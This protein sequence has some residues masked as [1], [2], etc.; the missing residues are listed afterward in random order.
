MEGIQTKVTLVVPV[1][2]AEAGAARFLA[3]HD[4]AVLGI[5]RGRLG[6]LTDIRPEMVR[7]DVAAVLDGRFAIEERFLL[8]VVVER[9][10]QG[11]SWGEALNDVVINSGR[12]DGRRDELEL[13]GPELIGPWYTETQGRPAPS[14]GLV[15]PTS[16]QKQPI[17]QISSCFVTIPIPRCGTPAAKQHP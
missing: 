14:Q 3:S 11:I 9:D 7:R 8:D 2:R 15:N 4:C 13:I 1:R 5:N 6:F 17:L 16:Q 10:G 12:S